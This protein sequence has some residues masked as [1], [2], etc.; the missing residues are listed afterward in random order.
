MR[1]AVLSHRPQVRMG[2]TAWSWALSSIVVG[3]GALRLH[4]QGRGV[5][6]L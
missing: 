2:N 1:M 3:I 5:E 4:A 6:A